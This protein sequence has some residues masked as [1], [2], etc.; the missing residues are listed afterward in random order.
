MLIQRSFRK[1]AVHQV[2]LLQQ[3][4]LLIA[5]TLKSFISDLAITVISHIYHC[6]QNGSQSPKKGLVNIPVTPR[7]N[8]K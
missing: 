1:A 3:H 8:R 7:N 6:Y 4:H 5:I 2:Y